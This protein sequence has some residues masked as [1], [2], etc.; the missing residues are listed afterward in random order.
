ML[1]SARMGVTAAYDKFYSEI[2]DLSDQSPIITLSCLSL[3]SNL[4]WC[5]SGIQKCQLKTCQC[6]WGTY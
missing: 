2:T 6:G 1:S 4:D 3:S 5:D